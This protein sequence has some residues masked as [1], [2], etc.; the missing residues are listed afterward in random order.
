MRMVGNSIGSAPAS[1]NCLLNALACSRVRVTNTRFPWSGVVAVIGSDILT[2]HRPTLLYLA[3]NLCC[4]LRQ[5]FPCQ[6]HA[7]SL[8][9]LNIHSGSPGYA[10]ADMNTLLSIQADH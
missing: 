2:L 8:G 5:C 3:N 1:A 9:I 10:V 7:Q 6:R 4:T